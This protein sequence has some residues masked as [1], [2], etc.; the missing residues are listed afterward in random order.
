MALSRRLGVGDR[1]FVEMRV[2]MFNVLNRVN[3]GNPNV[4]LG[5]ANFGRI[6]ATAG[7]PR[8]MQFAAKFVF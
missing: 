2:E 7:G 5:N 1:K 6:T 3:F 8:I 4:T